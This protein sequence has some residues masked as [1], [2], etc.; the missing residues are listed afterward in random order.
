MDTAGGGGGGGSYGSSF[1]EDGGGGYTD[2]LSKLKR[3]IASKKKDVVAGKSKNY[4]GEQIGVRVDN[5]F[6]MIHR[7]YQTK[8]KRNTFIEKG[9]A[10]K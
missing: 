9:V 1:G 7:R 6:E 5:I 10:K 4:G 8:R 3:G 2:Y